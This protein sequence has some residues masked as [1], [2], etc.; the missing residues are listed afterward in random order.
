MHSPSLTGA[1]ELECEVAATADNQTHFP[2]GCLTSMMSTLAQ[3]E[4]QRQLQMKD[5][6]QRSGLA[7]TPVPGTPLGQKIHRLPALALDSTPEHKPEDDSIA[8]T[9]EFLPRDSESDAG[10]DDSNVD[11]DDY[12][13]AA[14]DMSCTS[15][16]SVLS[17]GFLK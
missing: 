12:D 16:M 8:L 1:W 5:R 15:A 17:C 6:Q 14:C 7:G 3:Q 13:E 9:D 4:V 10:S 2:S 11:S